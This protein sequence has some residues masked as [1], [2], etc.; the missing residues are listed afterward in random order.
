MGEG[1]HACLIEL[2]GE[3]A[4]DVLLAEGRYRREVF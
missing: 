3:G 1:V 2:L 4:V